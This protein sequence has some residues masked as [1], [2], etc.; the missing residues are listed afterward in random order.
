M[1]QGDGDLED[2]VPEEAGVLHDPWLP[3]PKGYK[4]LPFEGEPETASLSVQFIPSST[5]EGIDDSTFEPTRGS[6]DHDGARVSSARPCASL[7]CG[8]L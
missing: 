2:P 8:G 7:V 1:S 6:G 3:A 4:L 5:S